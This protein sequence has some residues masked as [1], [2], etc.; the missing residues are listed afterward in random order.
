MKLWMVGESG[1]V[2]SKKVR[3]RREE[4]TVQKEE[5]SSIRSVARTRRDFMVREE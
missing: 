1:F 4:S 2:K 5:S 3:E